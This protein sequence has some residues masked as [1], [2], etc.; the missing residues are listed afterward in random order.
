MNKFQTEMSINRLYLVFLC[1]VILSDTIVR[2]HCEILLYLSRNLLI[3]SVY[4]KLL[5]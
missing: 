4:V 1:F 2:I 5:T 3:L